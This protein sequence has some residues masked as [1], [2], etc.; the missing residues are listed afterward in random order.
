M[1]VLITGLETGLYNCICFD[2]GG[3]TGWSLM[4]VR[5][6]YFRHHRESLV[7][8]VVFWAAGQYMG[9]RLAQV[10]EAM[11]LVDAWAP[12]Y[13]SARA[14]EW[15]PLDNL[16]V[17]AES[18]TLRQFRQDDTLLEPVRFNA[19]IE[20]ELYGMRPRRRLTEQAPSM[21]LREIPDSKL[22]DI[23]AYAALDPKIRG[24]YLSGTA[25]RPHARDALRHNFTF[26]Q[27]EK[28]ARR[29]KSGGGYTLVPLAGQQDLTYDTAL[30]GA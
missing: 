26:L 2:G 3:T 7:D 4:S 28:L 20:Q 19:A 23:D 1:G 30:Y 11:A 29:N 9:P 8:N 14:G 21:A 27:R 15:A 6:D 24:G 13:P 16:A 5:T 17:V 12:Q 10:E 22:C 18:F 25:G